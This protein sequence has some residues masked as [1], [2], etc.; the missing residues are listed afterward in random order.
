MTS[1]ADKS[2]GIRQTSENCVIEGRAMPGI[3]ITVCPGGIVDFDTSDYLRSQSV[4]NRWKPKT[5]RKHAEALLLCMKFA[6]TIKKPFSM[7]RDRELRL[8][9]NSQ[10]KRGVT[11]N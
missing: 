5:S 8:W 1:D 7:M 11:N 4:D 10:R 6:H 2:F 9:I 3:P